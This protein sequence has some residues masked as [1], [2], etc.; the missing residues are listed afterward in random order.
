M[1]KSP[2]FCRNPLKESCALVSLF[3]V[4]SRCFEETFV[5]NRVD[6][7]KPCIYWRKRWLLL[8]WGEKIHVGSSQKAVIFDWLLYKYSYLQVLTVLVYLAVLNTIQTK[9]YS[10]PKDLAALLRDRREQSATSAAAKHH[11]S[12]GSTLLCPLK[13]PDCCQIILGIMQQKKKKKKESLK[14]ILTG[15]F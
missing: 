4:F 7:P 11:R 5:C 12:V 9:W 15:A 3:K 1:K 10:L 2:G 14:E 6:A 8:R 13:Q